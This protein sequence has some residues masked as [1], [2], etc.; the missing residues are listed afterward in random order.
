MFDAFYP[1]TLLEKPYELMA[2]DN[3]CR[4]FL[5]AVRITFCHVKVCNTLKFL[6]LTSVLLKYIGVPPNWKS[7]TYVLKSSK[8]HRG[9]EIDIGSLPTTHVEQEK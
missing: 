7:V 4:T 2:D 6:F 1:L 5:Q 3:N 8:K 9:K